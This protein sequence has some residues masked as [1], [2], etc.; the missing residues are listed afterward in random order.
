MHSELELDLA[1]G[2]PSNPESTE[3]SVLEETVNRQHVVDDLLQLARSD[4]DPSDFASAPVD[5]DDIVLREA[6]R[7]RERDRVK[8]DL[9]G[10]SAAQTVGDAQQ[11]A[12]A[13][14]NLLDNA[15]RHA[16]TSVTITLAEIAGRVRLTV[17]DDGSGIPAG[18]RERIFERFSRLD[19]AR[20]RDAGGTGL[21]LA[22][23]RDIVRRSNGTI[24]IAD[25]LPTT[26]VVD[27][28]VAP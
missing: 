7:V 19:E 26:F 27:L 8:V 18:D 20:T 25:G 12:R 13:T 14:R 3:R 16:T 10:V 21:G 6:R 2:A 4:S 15:E 1:N 11:L 24:T 17:T 28:P 23:V 5:L 22:I 9:R